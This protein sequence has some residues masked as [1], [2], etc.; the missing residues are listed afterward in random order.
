MRQWKENLLLRFSIVSLVIMLALAVGISMMLTNRLNRDVDLLTDHGAAMMAGEM[1]EPA[2][3][4][5]IP[6]SEGRRQ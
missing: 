3:P 6:Q 1:I 5:S 2:A 4:F